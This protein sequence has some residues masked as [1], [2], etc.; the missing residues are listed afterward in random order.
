MK[1]VLILLITL[2]ILHH[3][4][5]AEKVNIETVKKIAV[6]VFIENYPGSDKDEIVI[7]RAIPFTRE[8]DT[9][10]YIFNFKQNGFVIISADN[11]APPVLG[12]CYNNKFE[13]A[14]IPPGL[15]YLLSRYVGEIY[16]LRA[17]KVEPTKEVKNKWEQLLDDKISRLKSAKGSVSQLINSTWAQGWSYNMYCPVDNGTH[18][19]AGCVAVAMAQVL[20]K[21][22][23]RVEGTG[24]HSYQSDYGTEYANFENA[25]YQWHAMDSSSSDQYNALL[26]YHCGVSTDM[27]YGPKSGTTVHKAAVALRN[28]FGFPDKTKKIIRW[29]HPFDWKNTLKGNLN[30]GLPIIY[31]ADQFLAP[32]HAWVVDGYNAEEEFHCNWGWNGLDD[33]YY[34]LGDF[35]PPHGGCYKYNEVAIIEIDPVR[36]TGVETPT[37]SPET[38]TYNPNG[39]LITIPEAEGAT[40]YEWTCNYGTIQGSG[41]N[42]TLYTECN[43]TV[44]V[45]AYNSQ[46]QIYSDYDS[47][48]MTIEYG[49]ITG[50]D[51][52]CY[53]PNETFTLHNRPSTTSVSWTNSSILTYVSGQGTDNYTVK[54]T[55]SAAGPGWVQATISGDCGDATIRKDNIWVGKPHVNP[56][57]I[58]F[59]CAD[60]SGYLCANAFGNEF[61]FTFDYPYNYFNIKLTNLSE[62]Q[63]YDQF[64][65]EDTWG[66]LDCSPPEGT[67]MF[68]VRGNNACGTGNWSKTTVD[69]VDCGGF[70]GFLSFF[71][72][73]ATVE[74][75]MELKTDNID[76]FTEGDEWEAEIFNRQMLLKHKTT[77]LKDKTCTINVSGWKKGIYYVRVRV[78]DKL[79]SGKFIVSR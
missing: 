3:L 7:D 57:T 20:Y 15:E 60:G 13:Q 46:C 10:F 78:K 67:H 42:V 23:C 1:K 58:Q 25:N 59:E 64:T 65:I 48:I 29:F 2:L 19:P 40:S 34:V 27:D 22:N 50:S 45:R 17:E 74:I 73:P 44:S 69:Y 16:C 37:L 56:A 61:S 14:T 71:P 26:I 18:V 68:H 38:F 41:T 53:S 51:I 54:A 76:T 72:N 24:Q 43:S 49:P 63:T 62:T 47:E 70:G 39:Y 33:G 30:R 9:L 52:V 79:V 75:T 55:P 4:S 5:F 36:S 12:Y 28:Y 77:R 66:T 6:K 8:N 11:V 31:G 21:W 35:C 32:G